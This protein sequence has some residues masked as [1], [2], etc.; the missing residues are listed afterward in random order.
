MNQPKLGINTGNRPVTGN[1]RDLSL[2][3]KVA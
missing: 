1:A 3:E 2:T